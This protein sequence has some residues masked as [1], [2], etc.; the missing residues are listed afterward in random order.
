MFEI[1]ARLATRLSRKIGALTAL[2]ES[3]LL[4]TNRLSSSLATEVGLLVALTTQFEIHNNFLSASLPS[5]LGALTGIKSWFRLDSNSFTA[6][7]RGARAP[8]CV[9]L[10]SAQPAPPVRGAL[11]LIP[12]MT[13]MTKPNYDAPPCPHITHRPAQNPSV[14]ALG[15]RR[16][17]CAHR[18]GLPQLEPAVRLG[19]DPDRGG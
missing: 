15:D 17:E 9:A 5:E 2:K 18:Q 11:A 10:S 6:E 1:M 19:R 12:S 14:G 7:V 13:L 16:S 3:M 4:D 8:L